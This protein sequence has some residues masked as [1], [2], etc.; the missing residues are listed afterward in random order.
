M[1]NLYATED[2]DYEAAELDNM[3]RESGYW[4]NERLDVLLTSAAEQ[5]P[6]H[7]GVVD[8]DRRLTYAELDVEA[9]DVARGLCGLGLTP[10]AAVILQLPNI[11][12]FVVIWFACVRAGLVPIH[13]TPAHRRSEVT[14]LAEAGSAE[15][16]VIKDQH[17]RFDYRDLAREVLDADNAVDRVVVVGD[18]P[19]DPRF[20]AYTDLHTV[21]TA[22]DSPLSSAGCRELGLLLLSGGTTGASK[23]IPRSHCD[24]LYNARAAAAA[25]GFDSDSVYLVVLPAAFNFTMACPGILGT[26]AVGGRVVLSAMS[27]PRANFQLIRDEGVI[28][29]ALTPPLALAWAEEMERVPA[30]V[31]SLR[32]MQVGGAKLEADLAA[33]LESAFGARVQQVFGMAEGLICLTSLDDSDDV[34][35]HTQGR[36]MSAGDEVLVVDE[37]DVDVP[38]G[39]PG[40]LLTRGPYTIRRYVGSTAADYRQAFTPN[41]FYRTGDVVTRREDGNL[42]VSGRVK[43]QINRGGEKYAAAEVEEHLRAHPAIAD[44]VVVADEKSATEVCVTAYLRVLGK[45]VSTVE[46]RKWLRE[47]GIASYKHPD[48][49]RVLDALPL[50]SLGKID[51]KALL[52]V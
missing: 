37:N 6:D 9:W 11:S 38:D 3:Y 47:R 12:E 43:D 5:W 18:T 19:T 15:L 50:T 20:F 25:T 30:Q 44:A 13:A 26:I 35:F 23:L 39:T 51:K 42:V 14:H 24:Y 33:R 21:G 48:Q 52:D 34:R 4:S 2:L 31:G 46:A 22:T 29:V 27:D 40:Q 41:G 28:S 16:Y 8:S 49:V 10:G 1:Q 7:V 17:A 32:V 36:P 45:P